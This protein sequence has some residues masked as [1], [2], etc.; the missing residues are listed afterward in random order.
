MIGLLD[1]E[2]S[3]I[4]VE[5]YLNFCDHVANYDARGR[6]K[7]L[8][9]RSKKISNKELSTTNLYLGN[10]FKYCFSH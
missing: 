2:K 4:F 7:I 8:L 1:Q 6:N 5:F 3:S 10:V 9:F